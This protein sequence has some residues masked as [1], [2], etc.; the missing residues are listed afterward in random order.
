V[1]KSYL[2]DV[3]SKTGNVYKLNDYAELSSVVIDMQ[4]KIC[5]GLDPC[6]FAGCTHTCHTVNQESFCTCPLDLMLDVD[7]KSCVAFGSSIGANMC[8][9]QNGGCDQKCVYDAP[10]YHCE[11][12]TGYRVDNNYRTCHDIDECVINNGGCEDKC[13]N[14]PG[15][16]FCLCSNWQEVR[17]DTDGMSCRP[18]CDRG[19]TYHSHACWRIYGKFDYWD[20]VGACKSVGAELASVDD[21]N[22]LRSILDHIKVSKN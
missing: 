10:G 1:P 7:F 5:K 11:C 17:L 6:D 20:A 14:Y 21:Q 15:G 13:V 16:H 3:A 4:S 2:N 8:M 18:L 9:V 12:N 19:F 22:D